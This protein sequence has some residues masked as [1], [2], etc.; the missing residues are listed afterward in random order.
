[1]RMQRLDHSMIFMLIAATFTP[2]G[3]LTLGGWFR[4]A[5]LSVAWGLAS[6]GIGA[7]TRGS[8]TAY[9]R[10]VAAMIGLGWLSALVAVPVGRQLGTGALALLAAGGAIYSIGGLLFAFRWPRLWPRAFSYHE[11]FHVL[12][13]LASVLHFAVVYHYLLPL[14]AAQG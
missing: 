13:V 7:V 1:Q 14:A 12:V 4:V 3:M 2:F 11:V 8:G 9:R 6:I 5:T 10:R